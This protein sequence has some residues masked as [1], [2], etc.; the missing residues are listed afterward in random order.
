LPHTI[1]LTPNPRGGS[2]RDA[3]EQHAADHLS[4]IGPIHRPALQIAFSAGVKK[5]P[6]GGL[7]LSEAVSACRA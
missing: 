5:P 4:Y 3:A 1:D 2:P 7:L 6:G